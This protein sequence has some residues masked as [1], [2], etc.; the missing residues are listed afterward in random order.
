MR[1]ETGRGAPRRR[2]LRPRL[3]KTEPGGFWPGPSTSCSAWA[4]RMSASPGACGALVGLGCVIVILGPSR[5]RSS[6][7]RFGAA[8]RKLVATRCQK[9]VGRSAASAAEHSPQRDQLV[10]R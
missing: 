8:T 7:D 5:R 9:S 3:A 10:L 1:A 6:S 4:V 2:G